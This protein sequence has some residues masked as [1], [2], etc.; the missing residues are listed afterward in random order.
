MH[1][2]LILVFSARMRTSVSSRIIFGDVAVS[3]TI[4]VSAMG[5]SSDGPGDDS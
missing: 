5:R 3:L 2:A 4:G 1:R